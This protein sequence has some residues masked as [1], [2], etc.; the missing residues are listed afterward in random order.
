MAVSQVCGYEDSIWYLERMARKQQL[1]TN[2]KGY[3]TANPL[4]K[5]QEDII[6][7]TWVLLQYV[8]KIDLLTVAKEREPY[9][10]SFIMNQKICQIVTLGPVPESTI[11]VI[12]HNEK[13]IGKY[14][15]IVKNKEEAMSLPK[16]KKPHIF[17]MID[18][19][20]ETP[21]VT[22]IAPKTEK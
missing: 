14:I 11:N 5:P 16:I 8:T 4:I 13:E 22:W 12:N 10:I 9:G 3:Y 15:F 21:S 19:T 20:K 17:A 1:F 7:A 18:Y 2:R 6:A